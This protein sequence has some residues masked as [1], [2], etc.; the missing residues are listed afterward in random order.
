MAEYLTF[1]DNTTMIITKGNV[2]YYSNDYSYASELKCKSRK[3][4]ENSSIKMFNEL[5]LGLL[6]I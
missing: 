3:S 2:F 5:D 4:E 6:I 1:K